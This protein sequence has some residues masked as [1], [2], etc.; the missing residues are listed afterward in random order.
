[1]VAVL[2]VNIGA[3]M[4]MTSVSYLAPH[5]ACNNYYIFVLHLLLRGT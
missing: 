3:I 5:M 4:P 1:M 2:K